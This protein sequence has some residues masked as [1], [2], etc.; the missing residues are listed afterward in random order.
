MKLFQYNKDD[1][2]KT[3]DMAWPAILESCLGPVAGRVVTRMVWS[4][5]A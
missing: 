5:G 2:K 1:V 4:K 3:L